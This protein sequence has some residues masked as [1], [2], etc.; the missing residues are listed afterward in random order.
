MSGEVKRFAILR[1][2]RSRSSEADREASSTNSGA[3]G[4]QRIY[5]EEYFACQVLNRI[6]TIRPQVFHTVVTGLWSDAGKMLHRLNMQ[7]SVRCVVVLMTCVLAT[8]R[9]E[10]ADGPTLFRVYL[11]DGSSL[12]TYGE[13]ARTA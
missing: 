5:A 3:R 11:T 2:R 1:S 13:F 9:A 8:G 6:C 4:F 12:V 7:F 10:A